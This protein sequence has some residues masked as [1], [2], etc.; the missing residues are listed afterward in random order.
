MGK[1]ELLWVNGD[2]TKGERP[3]GDYLSVHY[4]QRPGKVQAAYF[5]LSKEDHPAKHK[6]RWSQS[7]VRGMGWCTQPFTQWRKGVNIS[8][9]NEKFLKKTEK[10]G[11]G[12]G[13]RQL[14][15]GHQARSLPSRRGGESRRPITHGKNPPAHF[16]TGAHRDDCDLT[17]K[18]EGKQRKKRY[19]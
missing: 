14:F 2:V 8:G 9:A 18:K 3:V 12:G 1:K 7:H 17:Q 11:F 10:K 6:R 16:G 13:R 15:V 5:N 4:Q 19:S